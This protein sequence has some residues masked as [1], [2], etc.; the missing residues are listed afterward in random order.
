MF[1]G[2]DTALITDPFYMSTNPGAPTPHAIHES[3][4]FSGKSAIPH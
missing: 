4:L 3:V 2:K 1:D